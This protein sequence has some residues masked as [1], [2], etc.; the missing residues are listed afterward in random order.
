MSSDVI[1]PPRTFSRG[2]KV[3][4]WEMLWTP[5]VEDTYGWP[6]LNGKYCGP[7]R[8]FPMP[9]LTA[10]SRTQAF[11]VGGWDESYMNG[12][13]YEDNDFIGR[14]VLRT[15]R[16]MGEWGYKVYHQGHIQDAYM[17]EDKEIADANARNRER[18]MAK[19]G[20]IP[21]EAEFTPF[22]VSR[23][24][25]ESGNAV[26]ECVAEP[27]KLQKAID[28]TTGLVKEMGGTYAESA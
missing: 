5:Y 9:W 10:M 22:N 6:P 21:F 28:E 15:G 8:L 7:N 26:H 23:K 25:H 1:V 16:F 14:M 12:L 20:G 13:C 17:V 11:E 19:W 24:M 18:T 4:T 3:D 2:R 27:G